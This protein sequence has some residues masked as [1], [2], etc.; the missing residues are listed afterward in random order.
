MDPASAQVLAGCLKQADSRSSKAQAIFPTKNVP[1]EFARIVTEFPGGLPAL[2]G[3]QRE[4][5]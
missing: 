2:A 3:A 1:E 5:T 4:V